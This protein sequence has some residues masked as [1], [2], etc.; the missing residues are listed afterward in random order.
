MGWA[1]AHGWPRAFAE[2]AL[3]FAGSMDGYHLP[4]AELVQVLREALARVGPDDRDLRAR[5]LARLASEESFAPGS[6]RDELGREA[7]S[8]A[9]YLGDAALEVEIAE[10]PFAAISE[11]LS[12]EE[13]LALAE[14]L[15]RQG[16]ETRSDVVVLQ[17]RLLRLHALLASGE[18]ESF[19]AEH[20]RAEAQA[21]A[22][23]DPVALYR[24][25]LWTAARALLAGE[26]DRSEHIALAAFARV[27][28]GQFEGAAGFLGA[29]LVLAGAEQGRLP[30]AMP[31]LERD[32]E[33]RVGPASRCFLAWGYAE[34]DDAEGCRRALAR[35]VERDLPTL[36][37]YTWFRS[38]A[39]LLARAAWFVGDAA[40]AAA[41][42]VLLAPARG[43]VAVRGG[44][45]AH[46]PVSHALALLASLRGDAAA[47]A[48][49]FDEAEALARRMGARL[50]V[51]RIEKDRARSAARTD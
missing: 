12:L 5:L 25:Q 28:H 13:L 51:S 18:I 4:R 2:A 38:N 41:L 45:A 7:L 1:R 27:G 11:N 49:L 36:S 34:A 17:A 19:D 29:Q 46:G 6:R 33:L 37:R 8:L 10:T 42:E 20:A 48:A 39:C 16:E 26:P 15:Q 30:A 43:R 44:I 3:A 40:P 31:L 21:R 50:W 23:R 47:A 9:R 24:L 35:A 22:L 14:R 32:A